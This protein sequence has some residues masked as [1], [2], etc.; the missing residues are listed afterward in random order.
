MRAKIACNT[1]K[2][3]S[4]AESTIRTHQL[5]NVPCVVI[6]LV[7]VPLIRTPKMVP[8]GV[9]TPPLNSVPPITDAE[10]AVSYT[11]LTLPTTPYV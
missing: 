5:D 6:K 7:M 1:M 8:N 4:S 11:H 2:K 9:P 3:Q 10:I